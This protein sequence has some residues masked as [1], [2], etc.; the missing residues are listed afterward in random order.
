MCRLTIISANICNSEVFKRAILSATVLLFSIFTI[1]TIIYIQVT[2]PRKVANLSIS[3]SGGVIREGFI[4]F[5]MPS[6]PLP[7]VNSYF[8]FLINII[9]LTLY[10][11]HCQQLNAK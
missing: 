2:P 6:I 4:G 9:R 3:T 5:F 11:G 1:F 10:G 7:Y 8:T